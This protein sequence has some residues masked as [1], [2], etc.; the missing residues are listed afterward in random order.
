MEATGISFA[1]ALGVSHFAQKLSRSTIAI[2]DS[3]GIFDNMSHIEDIRDKNRNIKFIYLSENTKRKN[4]NQDF[5]YPGSSVG[6]SSEIASD[7]IRKTWIG[8]ELPYVKIEAQ[9]VASLKEAIISDMS[10]LLIEIP[11]NLSTQLVPRVSYERLPDGRF[12]QNSLLRM[13]PEKTLLLF[14]EFEKLRP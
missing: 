12:Q 2:T 4:W 7:R 9:D 11:V 8:Y 10:S 14:N 13:D 5:L 3:F 1:S 6:I